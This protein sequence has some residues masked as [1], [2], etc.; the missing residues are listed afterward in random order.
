MLAWACVDYRLVEAQ[1]AGAGDHAAGW[2]TSHLLALHPEV[3]GW[4]RFGQ[5][6]RDAIRVEIDGLATS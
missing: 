5:D 4:E 1:Y 3:H 6:H 2:E